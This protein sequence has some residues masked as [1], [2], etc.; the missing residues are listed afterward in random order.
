MKTLIFLMTLVPAIV[1]GQK[2]RYV[3]ASDTVSEKTVVVP[4]EVW[5]KNFTEEENG[6]AYLGDTLVKD[7][8]TELRFDGWKEQK[9]KIQRILLLSTE[10]GKNELTY[11]ETPITKPEFAWWVM[12]LV[13]CYY[14]IIGGGLMTVKYDKEIMTVLTVAFIGSMFVLAIIGSLQNINRIVFGIS[15]PFLAFLAY[16][17]FF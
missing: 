1:L 6:R 14:F 8:Y 7:F 5:N 4:D 17:L 3:K 2:V 9:F 11:I 10:T 12:I 13:F 16:L 15:V